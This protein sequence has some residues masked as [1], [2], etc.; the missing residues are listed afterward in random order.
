MTNPRKPLMGSRGFGSLLTGGSYSVRDEAT[1]PQE[2]GPVTD[3]GTC[4][5][6]NGRFSI[7]P[8]HAVY[9]RNS[10]FWTTSFFSDTS[11]ILLRTWVVNNKNNKKCFTPILHFKGRRNGR[12]PAPDAA[13][14]RL[15]LYLDVKYLNVVD[16]VAGVHLWLLLMKAHQALGERA[17]GSI[18]G[19]GIC[20][21]DFSILEILLHKGPLP[22]NAL[23][24]RI[25][26]T[27][28]SG[29]T[30]IDRL[31]KRGLVERRSL[32]SDR[33]VRIV[34][35]TAAGRRLIR[36]AF[37]Q[38]AADMEAAAGQLSQDDRIRLAD[39]LRKL[40]K[41]ETNENVTKADAH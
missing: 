15:N 27:S 5:I 1:G 29:T 35:L 6:G 37:E 7:R 36:R 12:F 32:V 18:A 13:A 8:P 33:R 11:K 19:T 38:H 22:V 17:A 21:T 10:S 31:E 3:N 4:N 14:N 25:G 20:F 2:D 26:L 30:A 23:A 39:L 9:Y 24:E 41:G 16:K 40:G 28:G 34:H